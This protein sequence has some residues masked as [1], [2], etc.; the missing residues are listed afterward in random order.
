MAEI[1]SEGY[2]MTGYEARVRLVDG[3]T[4]TFHWLAKPADVQAAA[5]KAETDL[6]YG[7]IA[8]YRRARYATEDDARWLR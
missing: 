6:K 7:E 8:A 1:L 3:R 5:D 2:V 4:R